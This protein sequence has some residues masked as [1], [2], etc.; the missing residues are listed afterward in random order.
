MTTSTTTPNSDS[1]LAYVTLTRPRRRWLPKAVFLLIIL[2]CAGL[3]NACTS[4]HQHADIAAPESGASNM[5]WPVRS[6]VCVDM[7]AQDKSL[8]DSQAFYN[9]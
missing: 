5:A 4:A 2:F 8:G 9:F 6:I 1:A 7:H 3:L